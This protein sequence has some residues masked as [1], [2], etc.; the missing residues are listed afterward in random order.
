MSFSH[1]LQILPSDIDIM[2]HVNNVVYV[3]WVQDVA[4]A[5]WN[6]IAT[7]ELKNRY[8]WVVLRHEIDY[9]NP[10]LPDDQISGLTWVGEHSGAR[11]E[12]FVNLF[13]PVSRKIFVQAKT[14]WCL[15]DAITKR[16]TRIPPE[17]LR[18]F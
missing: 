15:L 8:L 6:Q 13:S 11:F 18:M 4:A 12:R 14:T 5:H 2:G 10:A 16:P 9:K 7:N 1:P 17:I 3:R